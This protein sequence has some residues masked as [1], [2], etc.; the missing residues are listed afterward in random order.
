MTTISEPKTATEWLTHHQKLWDKQPPTGR[1][2]EQWDLGYR[3]GFEEAFAILSDPKTAIPD[4]WEHTDVVFLHLDSG[5]MACFGEWEGDDLGHLVGTG[6]IFD[7]L[8]CEITGW[9]IM[10]HIHSPQ[11]TIATDE[12]NR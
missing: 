5:S 6:Y 3:Q 10:R 1:D 4:G 2:Y 8:V 11:F 12:D 9:E 7:G